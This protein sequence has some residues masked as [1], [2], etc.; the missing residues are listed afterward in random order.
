MR[1]TGGPAGAALGIRAVRSVRA[2]AARSVRAAHSARAAVALFGTSSG[3]GRPRAR[4]L[5]LALAALAVLA[6]LVPAAPG[7]TRLAVRLAAAVQGLG[8]TAHQTAVGASHPVRPAGHPAPPAGHPAPPADPI[9]ALF[10]IT[11]GAQLAGGH[12][13]TASVVDSPQG[14]LVM[15]A[16]HCVSGLGAGQFAFVPGFRDGHTPYGVWPVSRVTVDHAWATSADPDHDVA[17]LQVRKLGS[18]NTVQ[19]VTGGER[20]GLG[21]PAGQ[22]VRVT[23]YPDRLSAPISCENR[24]TAFSPTQ[25][26]FDCGG[27]TSGTSGSPLL[28]SVSLTTGLG[29][30]IGVIG[31]YQ[32]GGDTD[33]VSYAARLGAS[34]AALYQTATSQP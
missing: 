3:R 16:A 11:H 31:G 6:V 22:F 18:A 23:G 10:R 12:F 9:G 21:Q 27:Y 26:R 20:L 8:R 32:Q 7:G 29:T 25:L 4:T 15:T 14:D 1:R 34:A 19:S 13:C 24:V 30:V 28:A 2:A 5:V 17:F 33:S